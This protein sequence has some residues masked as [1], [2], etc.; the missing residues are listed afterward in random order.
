M[1]GKP[2][3]GAWEYEVTGADRIM[4]VPDPDTKTVLIFYAGKHPKPP[5]PYPP[6][7]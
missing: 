5:Y 1:K 2:Y 7:L 3:K 4:Y 6:V